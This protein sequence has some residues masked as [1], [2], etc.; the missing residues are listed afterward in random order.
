MIFAIFPHLSDY[1][2]HGDR[3][4]KTG[5]RGGPSPDADGT[6]QIRAARLAPGMGLMS[7]RSWWRALCFARGTAPSRQPGPSA[8]APS[9]Q[10]GHQDRGGLGLHVN[11]SRSA[12]TS[13]FYGSG[14]PGTVAERICVGKIPVPAGAEDGGEGMAEAVEIIDCTKYRSIERDFR[15]RECWCLRL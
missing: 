6:S 14:P 5:G 12:G 9:E 7:P 1:R 11:H 3:D 8:K 13:T 10:R 2:P 4:R 15:S